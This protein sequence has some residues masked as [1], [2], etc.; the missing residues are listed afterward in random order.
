M[1]VTAYNSKGQKQVFSDLAWKSLGK[2]KGDWSEKPVQAIK[3]TI[4]TEKRPDMGP[5]ISNSQ[6]IENTL[7]TKGKTEEEIV[8][9]DL[10]KNKNVTDESKKAEFMKAVEGLSRTAIKDFFDK[11]T[12][13][14]SYKNG[15]KNEAL[16]LQLA[17]HLKYDLV[18][19]QK[20][21]V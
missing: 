15:S 13:R 12:P 6:K 5:P 17:E 18:E 9:D 8:E 1:S 14:V 4:I 10:L 2:N 3:N 16:Q 11:Q 20:S 21:F 7:E 19:F